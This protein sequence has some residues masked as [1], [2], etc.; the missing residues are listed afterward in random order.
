MRTHP[1]IVCGLK[2]FDLDNFETMT[3]S[4]NNDGTNQETMINDAV[5]Q[6]SKS[7]LRVVNTER[8]G[9]RERQVCVR[10]RAKLHVCCTL[11][12]CGM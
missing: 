4:M 3:N 5:S 10:W 1:H 11:D 12:T 6:S 8:E 2:Q 7:L 9:G